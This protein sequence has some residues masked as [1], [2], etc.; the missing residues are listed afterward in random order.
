MTILVRADAPE[1]IDELL[2]VYSAISLLDHGDFDL[3][4]L[5]TYHSAFYVSAPNGR[6]YPKFAPGQ[7]IL[8]LP[9]AAAARPFLPEHSTPES[10]G[11]VYLQAALCFGH[12]AIPILGVLAFGFWTHLGYGSRPS[13]ISA[14][15][16][17]VSTELL[18]YSRS[19]FGDVS[20]AVLF[21][22]AFAAIGSMADRSKL[23]PI[24]AGLCLGLAV[25]VR[26]ISALFL[27]PFAL[28][29]LLICKRS[30]GGISGRAAQAGLIVFP[31]ILC[32]LGLLAFNRHAYG[33]ALSTGYGSEMFQFGVSL[34][35]GI[36]HLLISLEKGLFPYSP[37]LLGILFFWPRFHRRCRAESVS[38]LALAGLFLL[39]Y[40]RWHAVSPGNELSYGQRFLL[41]IVPFLALALP[42]AVVC[43]SGKWQRCLGVGVLAGSS[44]IQVAGCLQQG[45]P[46][47]RWASQFESVPFAPWGYTQLSID[48]PAGVALWW[49]SRGIWAFILAAVLA[50]LAAG[51]AHLAATQAEN[52]PKGAGY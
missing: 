4:L 46:Y 42:E 37:V 17:M 16:L 31:I 48:H 49:A 12:V 11:R 40:G 35:E 25:L 27:A 8:L 30:G 18:P 29:F 2:P 23:G 51:L 52:P 13:A 47:R 38:A 50:I 15:A 36:P 7:A 26:P 34:G 43:F 10:R 19:V 41:P 44:L 32:G 39:V 14:L 5:D 1:T 20:C 33:G 22:A 45:D 6:Y 3:P 9:F 21:F 28:Y 24:G